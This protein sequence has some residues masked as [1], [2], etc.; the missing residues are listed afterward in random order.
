VGVPKKTTRFFGY[1]PGCLNPG[2]N[3]TVGLRRTRLFKNSRVKPNQDFTAISFHI[4]LNV[5]S[6]SR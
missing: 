4:L 3:I 2:E 5:F 6:Y 1:I